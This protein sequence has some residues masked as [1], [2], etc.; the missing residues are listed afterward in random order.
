VA[1]KTKS[2]TLLRS[3]AIFPN[4]PENSPEFS[5]YKYSYTAYDKDGNI[6]TEIRYAP[7]GSESEKKIF[8]FDERG[9]LIE[10]INFLDTG[11]IADHMTFE[12]DDRGKIVKAF[13]HYLDGSAD[14]IINKYNDKGN[15]VEKVTIDSDEGIEAKE[16]M[17]YDG[18]RLVNHKI[19]EYDELET[20]FSYVYDNSGN[21][22]SQSKWAPDEE[23][24]RYD[25]F[26]DDKGNLIK[27]LKYNNEEQL[28][29]R[30]V[31]QYNDEGK[32]VKIE[33]E[34]SIGKTITAI[35]YDGK[36]N[37]IKQTVMD[38]NENINNQV[39]H[40]YNEDNL[41]I[42]SEVFINL[43]G[44]VINQE[45]KLKYEYEFYDEE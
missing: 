16:I 26:F 42:G 20:E 30:Y 22:T 4:G 38:E 28:T 9:R 3:D 37:A 5:T 21:I 36:G 44:R 40:E 11:E 2:I 23:L 14:T 24:S 27:S 35:E 45:Y 12:R 41:V 19:F 10:E 18:D 6:T 31:Y 8:S 1:K 32:T 34:T 7:D 39:I 15:L 29:E 17:V 33:E 25:N 13:K 43:Q